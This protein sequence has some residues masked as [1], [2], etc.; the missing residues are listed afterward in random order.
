MPNLYLT[1]RQY[2]KATILVLFSGLLVITSA[3]TKKAE[4][5][6]IRIGFSQAMTTDE[7]RRQMNQ[8]MIVEA[9]LHPETE[10]TIKDARNSVK[11]Q[12]SDIEK[13]ISDKVDIL[14]VSPIEAQPL[15]AVIKKALNSG[16]PVIAIDRK[17]DNEDF[18]AF[19]G[20]DNIEV[21]RNAA[22]YIL[23]N[24]T[25]D[26]HIVEVTGAH[27]SSPAYERNLGF[28]QMTD[29]NPRLKIIQNISGDW[30]LPSAKSQLKQLLKE[31]KKVDYIFS[32]NDRMALG[33]WE[34][35][36]EM[37][38]EKKIKIIGV[39][40]LN[41]PNGG[42]ELVKNGALAA[43]ILYPNGGNE[44]IKLAITIYN[45]EPFAKNNILNTIVVDRNNAEIIEN[46]MDKV[47]QQQKVIE[48]QL[49]AIEV[50][51]EEFSSQKHLVRLLS[52][53]LI[54][55]LA[56]ALYSVYSTISLKKKKQQLEGFNQTVTRQKNELEAMAEEARRNNEAKFSFFTGL[57]HEFKTP[58]TL[59]I[60][61]AESLIENEK[62]K[63]TKLMEEM[64][65]IYT[66]SNRLLRLINQLLDFRKIEERKFTLLASRTNIYDFTLAL[67]AN[68]KAE[69][70]RRNI[71]F[72]VA[73]D[74]RGTDVFIDRGLMDKVY[75]NLLSNAFKFT[76]DN[77]KIKIVIKETASHVK[78]MFRDSGIGIPEPELPQVFNPF[79]KAS[80]NTKNSSGIGLNIAREF[81]TLHKGELE[82]KSLHGT[83]FILSLHKGTNHL[84]ATEINRQDEDV[85]AGL[86]KIQ[87]FLI[88]ETDVPTLVEKRAKEERYSLL[89]IED[90]P[91]LVNF[92]GNKLGTDYN[93][94]TSDGSD[95]VSIALGSIPD[96]IICDINLKDTDGFEI[97][98]IIKKDLRTSHI[99]VLMLTALSNKESMLKGLQ[100]GVDAYLTKP[101]SLSVLQ[102]S[103]ETLLFNREK[104]RYYYTNNIYKVNPET[105]FGN[106]EQDFI[107][108]MNAIIAKNLEDPKFS[109]EELAEKM[110]VSRVQLYRKVKAILGINISDHINNI[111]LERAS[112][113]LKGGNMNVSEVAYALGYSSPNYFSTAFKNKYGISPKDFKITG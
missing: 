23:A 76:P 62:V 27:A 104:L 4:D 32:H 86:L 71:E 89:I 22:K 88:S 9:S 61:Y 17:T 53:F 98:R 11:Q 108:K 21:G 83:E 37:G 70:V 16:I 111:K 72:I 43:T 95:A 14:L 75:F 29:L 35:T 39:D 112:E 77:G 103:L 6:K 30:E 40:A 10:L 36:K 8:S 73:C 78:I 18:T 55:I 110:L 58:L 81:V 19:I 101:F 12:I 106:L 96:V 52:F 113:M 100:A 31:Q 79:F 47:D 56:L 44:A 84:L 99:P 46:Q 24:T 64:K 92:L 109:V 45:R 51:E 54:T 33:A 48:G 68:F 7:W 20:A 15:D 82:V 67:M 59:I 3:C 57:S 34:A 74:N 28:R 105:R 80:N 2:F 107:T 90:H 66:N 26:V 25:G 94:T 69:A 91:D 93:V 87:D 42:I 60:S 1:L 97:S 38:M 13:L 5:K 49:H 50:Q 41:T 102:R 65:L 63:G 85:K